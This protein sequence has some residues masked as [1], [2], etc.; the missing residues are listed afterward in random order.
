MKKAALRLTCLAAGCASL[1]AVAAPDLTSLT[2]ATA[3]LND[4]AAIANGLA[5]IPIPPEQAKATQAA[6]SNDAATD[7]KLKVAID[8]AQAAYADQMKD[9]GAKLD[10]CAKNTHAA[11]K[12]AHEALAT[13]KSQGNVSP[14]DAK[15]M[16]AAYQA[17]QTARQGMHAAIVALL[18]NPVR[19]SYLRD[20]LNSFFQP[21]GPNSGTGPRRAQQ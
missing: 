10:A 21:G 5:A 2:Q 7:P 4:C 6:A 16:A 19:A 20:P 18:S 15:A 8:P 14:D 1:F 12:Q 11:A 13:V 3:A 9:G 17:F